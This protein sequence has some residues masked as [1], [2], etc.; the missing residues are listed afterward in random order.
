MWWAGSLVSRDPLHP[1][2]MCASQQQSLH[3]PCA[4]QP[5]T[6]PHADLAAHAN[7][8]FYITA[9]DLLSNLTGS[10]VAFD[11]E[12]PR[13]VEGLLWVAKH[14]DFLPS[15]GGPMAAVV[16]PAAQVGAREG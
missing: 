7:A 16:C 1:V 5:P 8:S 12:C 6:H 3:T 4:P 11:E 15:S 14:L 9:Q 10:I 2:C 13:L